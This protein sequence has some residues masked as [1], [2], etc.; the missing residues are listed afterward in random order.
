[1]S[2][3]IAHVA[4]L[5]LINTFLVHGDPVVLDWNSNPEHIIRFSNGQ[6]TTQQ[7]RTNSNNM[8]LS[9][10]LEKMKASTCESGKEHP[11]VGVVQLPKAFSY[12]CTNFNNE[13]GNFKWVQ[14]TYNYVGLVELEASGTWGPNDEAVL[15]A[16]IYQDVSRCSECPANSFCCQ[17]ESSCAGST[18]EGPVQQPRTNVSSSIVPESTRCIPNHLKCNRHPNCGKFCNAD[19]NKEDCGEYVGGAFSVHVGVISI[20]SGLVAASLFTL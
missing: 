1:M 15:V 10:Q 20:V 2:V 9:I 6:T 8:K 18:V 7:I 4:T 16:T 13:G 3:T 12:F 14:Y 5:V 11:I 19:E 17:G